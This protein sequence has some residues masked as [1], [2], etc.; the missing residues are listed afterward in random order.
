MHMYLFNCCSL[1]HLWSF[2]IFSQLPS[3]IH[4][5][6]LSLT[7]SQRF[8]PFMLM[9]NPPPLVYLIKNQL[10]T[11][12]RW[13]SRAEYRLRVEQKR[14]PHSLSLFHNFS[15]FSL[16]L[17]LSL[18]FPFILSL[19]LL[20]KLHPP[21]YWKLA[22]W[23]TRMENLIYIFFFPLA[24]SHLFIRFFSQPPLPVSAVERRRRMEGERG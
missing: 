24:S 20:S 16:A 23:F 10:K 13:V 5:A 21:V 6:L 17:F 7:S 3:L 19:S 18:P 15:P 8:I 11:P 4:C 14:F 1:Q 12:R 22:T 2:L 9:D